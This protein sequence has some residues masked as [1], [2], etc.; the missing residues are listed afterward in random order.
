MML[1]NLNIKLHTSPLSPFNP[2][3]PTS[4]FLILVILGLINS[5]D[6]GNPFSLCYKKV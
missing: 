5:T 6:P 4:P 1:L 2:L 3:G